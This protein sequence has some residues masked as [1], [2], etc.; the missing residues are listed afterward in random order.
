MGQ[1][2]Q[3]SVAQLDLRGLKC[4]LPAMFARRALER[5]HNGAEIE[6]LTDDPLAPLDVPHMCRQDGFECVSL[7]RDGDFARM[8]LRRPTAWARAA[9]P[10]DPER[11]VP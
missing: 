8:V 7:A 3:R 5:A 11:P 10:D 2:D 4:P 9:A 1:D 6:I